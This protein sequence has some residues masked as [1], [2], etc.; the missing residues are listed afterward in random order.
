MNEFKKVYQPRTTLVKGQK[1]DLLAD[2]HSILKR[3]KKYFCQLLN[4]R[5]IS[6]VRHT[7]IQSAE[8]LLPELSAL[9]LRWLLRS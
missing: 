9:M 1:G 3:L 2:S 7:E 8:P 5:E 4:I 6:D